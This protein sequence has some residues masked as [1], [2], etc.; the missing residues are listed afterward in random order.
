[1]RVLVVEDEPAIAAA[2]GTILEQASHAVDVAADGS[3]VLVW[4]ETYA[5]D[6]I[7]LYLVLPGIDGLTV[8]RRLR[9]NAVSTRSSC[10]LRSTPSTIA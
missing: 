6:L 7:I 8:C 4:T 3:D 1:M 10:S 9:A 2:V 5:Y